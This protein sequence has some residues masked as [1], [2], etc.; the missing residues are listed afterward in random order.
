[1]TNKTS[2]CSFVKIIKYNN[3][4]QVIS[5][6][7]V[8]G[9]VNTYDKPTGALQRKQSIKSLWGSIITKRCPLCDIKFTAREKTAIRCYRCQYHISRLSKQQPFKGVPIEG[10]RDNI[11]EHIKSNPEILTM[12]ISGWFK[13]RHQESIDAL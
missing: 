4:G 6:K 7:Y 2:S 5:S 11:I 3:K 8:D 9:F 10:I 1:M 12:P 13:E